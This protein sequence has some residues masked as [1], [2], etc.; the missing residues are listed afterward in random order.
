MALLSGLE[1][2]WTCLVTVSRPSASSPVPRTVTWSVRS[3]VTFFVLSYALSW[4]WVVPWAATGH[5][6]VQG[7]GWPTHLPSLLGPMLA[8]FLV[9]GWTSRSVGFRDLLVRMVRWRIGWRWW[10]V[11]IGPL[12]FFVLLLAVMSTTGIDVPASGDFASFSGMPA[13]WGLLGVW[14]VVLVVNG[15]G[16]ETGWRGYALPRL[17]L[18]FGPVTGTLIL[19]GA[20]AGWHIPQFFLLDSYQ[21]FSVVMLPVFVLGLFCGAV[22]L[23][24]L[25]NHTGGSIFAVVVWHALYNLTGATKAAGA[26]AGVLASAMWTFVVVQAVILLVLEWR[27]HR[28][29]TPSVLGRPPRAVSGAPDQPG[30]RAGLRD[31]RELSHG[32]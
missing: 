30:R 3:I 13:D 23:T 12:L 15:Y 21:D 5:T 31:D 7:R 14:T 2:G 11:A 20:W 27:A 10:L 25:Y 4:A 16:E 18:R 24:W 19:A 28:A 6:V 8:A 9:T 17:E 26:G 1:R 29:G 22:V 32:G